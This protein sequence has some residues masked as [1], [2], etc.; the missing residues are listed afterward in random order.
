[1]SCS[2]NQ[3]EVF[4]IFEPEKKAVFLK[5]DGSNMRKSHFFVMTTVGRLI[6]D[7]KTAIF[8]NEKPYKIGICCVSS[9]LFLLS[10]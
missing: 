8:T 3:T 2:R 4:D 10:D 6:Y 5:K 7:K 1:V 9:S